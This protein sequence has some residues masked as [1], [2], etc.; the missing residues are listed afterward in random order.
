MEITDAICP[1]C[2]GPSKDG[3]LCG[4]C[5]AGSVQWF[6]CDS[7]VTIIQCGGCGSLKTSGGWGDS[8]REREDLEEDAALSAVKFHQD[9]KKPDVKIKLDHLSN[10]RT[11]ADLDITGTLYGETLSGY[12]TIEIVWQNESCDRCNRQHGNYYEGIIQVR[13]DGRK[14]TPEEQEE[15]GRIAVEVETTMQNE[16]ERLSFISRFDEGREGLDIVVGSQAIGEQI[17]REIT[18]RLGGRFS[19]HPTL[20]GEKNGQKLY[21]ITYLVRLP[22]LSRGDVIAVRNTY[23]EVLR[24]EGRTLTYLD[25]RTGIPRT[26][27]ES[28]PARL[29][30]NIRDAD[31]YS[32][33]YRDGS[34]LGI[35]DSETGK[36]E[37]ISQINWR[38]PEVGDT[39][40]I[41][42]DRDQI[43]VV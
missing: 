9:I 23:G 38:N 12:C 21:R 43:I 29:I 13:A 35:L 3:D 16:G 20:V 26:I 11:Y 8:S 31:D 39:V 4:K 10:N 17:S 14:A 36:T 19:L 27:P 24:S 28:T 22:R 37:E 6:N 7:R 30:A 33:I 32:V 2:G 40:R 5:L 1:K 42:R 15:A 25:L 18:T 41:L 34:V